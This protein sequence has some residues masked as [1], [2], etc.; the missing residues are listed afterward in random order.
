ME[1]QT[2]Y[3]TLDLKNDPQLIAEYEKHHQNVWPEIL[4]SIKESG[5]EQMEIYR[6]D[7]RL[8]MVMKVT[9]TFN[10]D[11][12]AAMDANN[13]KV[14]EWER[15]MWK[16]QQALPTAKPGEKWLFMD[17]IFSLTEQLNKNVQ[18]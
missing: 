2:F 4:E 3:L 13:P 16:Y 15:L 5:I 17:K 6:S 11:R 7:N 18:S 1:L 10:F 14:Q 9:A 12:K 8:F